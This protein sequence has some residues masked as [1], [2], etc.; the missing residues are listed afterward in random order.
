MS[1]EDFIIE[2]FCQVDDLMFDAEKHP[3][4]L[5]YPSEVV[6]LALLFALKGSGN[7]AFYRW[8]NRDWTHLF[9][10]LPDRTRLFRLFNSH[11]HWI[12]R[13]MAAPSLL[14]VIDSYG[15]ELIHPRREGRSAKQIG[16]K[17]LSNK[18]WIVGGKLCLLLNNIGLVVDW[19][20]DTANVYD[21]TAFQDMVDAVADEML[22]FADPHFKKAGW[23][24]TNLKICAKGTW[25][26]RMMVE[27]VLSMLTVVCHF[28]KV[29]HRVWD[30][31]KSRV[32]YTMALFN[33]LVQWPGIEPDEDG[34]VK[35]SIAE[36]SL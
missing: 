13:F 12:K 27:T 16:K 5:L 1:T 11:R 24:P 17:G 10:H 23:E 25:N 7:R 14:G 26:D 28:K 35:L 20:V 6:T 15:I 8:L 29:G 34:F 9:P 21:G 2:L 19:D 33:V 36:F 4:A 3:Q 32:G 31:F 18:R 22:V 30:Y